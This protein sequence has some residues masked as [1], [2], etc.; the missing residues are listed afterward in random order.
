MTLFPM[1]KH[2]LRVMVYYKVNFI[3]SFGVPLVSIIYSLRKYIFRHPEQKET[4]ELII[5]WISYMIVLYALMDSG[6]ALVRL[7]EEQFLKMFL[8]I[9]RNKWKVIMARFFSHLIVLTASAVLFDL[10]AS[11]LFSLPF[12]TLLGITAVMICVCVI[13]VYSLFLLFAA[14]P[15]RQETIQPI[16]NL[17]IFFFL[18]ITLNHFSGTTTFFN[19]L[20]LL[21]NPMN[22]AFDVGLTFLSFLSSNDAPPV[23]WLLLLLIS[24]IYLI[25]GFVSI[26]NMKILPIFRN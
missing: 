23:S 19:V 21:T 6:S 25:I 10:I 16:V 3:F 13:P 22:Y 2:F 26:I 17:L 18:I 5:F 14:L 4:I 9:S 12:G 1:T 15:F 20:L 8:F 7:R 11:I 24:C